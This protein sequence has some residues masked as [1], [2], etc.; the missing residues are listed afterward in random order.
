M[1]IKITSNLPLSLIQI[2]FSGI[3]FCRFLGLFTYITVF[4]WINET[5]TKYFCLLQLQICK[6]KVACYILMDRLLTNCT[7]FAILS[8]HKWFLLLS[9]GHLINP[10]MWTF[11]NKHS[12]F[13]RK[14]CSSFCPINSICL[15]NG[16]RY[17]K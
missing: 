4:L 16:S 1:F 14:T 11:F 7:R 5:S 15:I 2:N 17:T 12:S 10:L 8:W 13:D 3:D 9:H 6:I